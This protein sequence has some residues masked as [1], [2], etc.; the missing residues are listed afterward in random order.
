MKNF[1]I[2]IAAMVICIL[3]FTTLNAQDSQVITQENID[4]VS[5]LHEFGRGA[6]YDVAYSGDGELLAIATL[7]GIWLHEGHNDTTPALIQATPISIIGTAIA[8]NHDGSIIAVVSG[9]SVILWDTVSNSEKTTITPDNGI[10]SDVDFPNEGHLL[11]IGTGFGDIIIWDTAT[12]TESAILDGHRFNVNI[13]DFSADGQRLISAG[14]DSAL[15]MW[16]VVSKEQLWR[17]SA[18]SPIEDANISLDGSK[19]VWSNRL[20]I[21]VFD[22][23]TGQLLKE[24]TGQLDG[25]VHIVRFNPTASHIFYSANFFYDYVSA[26]RIS[27]GVEQQIGETPNGMIELAFN[28][29]YPFALMITSDW[30]V[31]H[32]DSL[33]NKRITPPSNYLGRFTA[34]A[35]AERTGYYAIGLGNGLLYIVD[36]SLGYNQIG[37]GHDKLTT[38]I[39]AVPNSSTFIS[40]GVDG[41]AAFWEDEGGQYQ[42]VNRI[43]LDDNMIYEVAVS[44]DG[45]ILAYV[46]SSDSDSIRFANLPD[47]TKQDRILRG[48]T[49]TISK[50]V[51]TEDGRH[52]ISYSEENKNLRLWDLQTGETVKTLTA[53]LTDIDLIPSS[54][55]VLLTYDTQ[56]V[57]WEIETDEMVEF[58]LPNNVN[59]I[60]T[61]IHPNGTIIA[62]TD[63][64]EVYWFGLESLELIK[65]HP[66]LEITTNITFT[67]EGDYLAVTSLYGTLQV[68]GV[69]R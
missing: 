9:E 38:A 33:T 29:V 17:H 40:I 65:Q 19:V 28:P 50:L 45:K 16:D 69:L 7:H 62:V 44:P 41:Q 14:G 4:R 35:I 37:A 57:F 32:M 3:G 1:S 53:T 8:V 67:P 59:A 30:T 15:I 34:F 49:K 36:Q 18:S 60:D 22:G 52:L 5:L 6:A 24:F 63:S 58:N 39:L 55:S 11:A 68:W 26:Y 64:R 2:S 27:D 43:P 25:F 10:I 47:L 48:H 54:Q 20:Q 51:F 23:E 46:E 66:A 61:T 42:D 13:V 12:N 21:Y 56:L 31:Y